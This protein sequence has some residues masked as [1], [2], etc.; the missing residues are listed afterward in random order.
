MASLKNVRNV[1]NVERAKWLEMDVFVGGG[2]RKTSDPVLPLH[3][4]WLSVIFAAISLLSYASQTQPRRGRGA[5]LSLWK[6]RVCVYGLAVMERGEDD[7]R[8]GLSRLSHRFLAVTEAEQSGQAATGEG[9][10]P[11]WV[12]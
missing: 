2:G 11:A 10:L 3:T 7:A 6:A 4:R 1:Y 9:Y 8:G 12:G 5:G